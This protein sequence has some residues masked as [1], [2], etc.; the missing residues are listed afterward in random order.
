MIEA[1][2][3]G[4][5]LIQALRYLIGMLYSQSASASLLIT[6]LPGSYDPASPGVIDLATFRQDIILLGLVAALPL[7]AVLIGRFRFSMIVAVI[8]MIAGR[9]ALNILPLG[10]SATASASLV[11]AGGFLYIAAIVEQRARIFPYFF[12]LGLAVDQ[13]IRAA[14][15]TLDPTI[16]MP[17]DFRWDYLTIGALV[18]L[19]VLAVYHLL[20]RTNDIAERQRDGTSLNLNRGVFSIWGGLGLGSFLYLELALLATPNAIAAKTGMDYTIT[21]P[22][23]IAATLLPLIP[24]VRTFIR[25]LIAPFDQTIRGW[26]WFVFLALM[27]VLGTRIPQLEISGIGSIPI[28]GAALIIAQF[29]TTISWWWYVRPAGEKERNW[30]AIWLLFSLLIL[31]I[32]VIADVFT[33]EYAYVRDFAP[34]LESLN[35][36]VPGI[37]RGF[38]GFGLGI[39]LLAVLLAIA[40]M[41]QSGNRIPLI[42]GRRIETALNALLIIAVVTVG[43]LFARP[44][45]VPATIGVPSIRV[46]T[47][48][49]HSGYNEFFHFSLQEIAATI[50]QSGASVLLLQEVEAGRLTSF[51]VDQTLWL[52]RRLGMDRRFYPT[53]E[54][55]QGLAVLSSVPIVYADGA[56]IPSIDQQTGLQRVQ[57]QPDPDL[58]SV[59]T[60]YNTWLGLLL[61]GPGLQ[62]LEE[63]QRIQLQAILGIINNHRL[64]DYGGQLGRTILGGTFHNVPGSPLLQELTATSFIDPFAGLPIELSATLRR[65]NLQPVRYDYLWLWSQTLP[66]LGTNVMPGAGS[67]HRLAVVEVQL[68]RDN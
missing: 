35:P 43:A 30:G 63:N 52:A 34:P 46:G 55:L 21:V 49:L 45:L 41:I 24:A 64:N 32:F 23:L 57:I 58:N 42:A 62:D 67:D 2:L 7:F 4:W 17:S 36:I 44:P 3:A 22:L 38:R 29:L 9:I 56:L 18:A 53:N 25:S 47:Y 5:L 10:L 28:A 48:N 40:P 51:G 54:G 1:A 39:L 12:V 11:I 13:V 60:I 19:A 26:I 50:Q 6:Y 20:S 68:R 33:F 65:S 61:Q 37:L 16:W 31:G 15:N 14:G 27:V 59:I 8:L 66:P